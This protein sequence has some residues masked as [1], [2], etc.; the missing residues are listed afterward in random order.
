M[1]M[2]LLIKNGHVIDPANGIDGVTDIYIENGVVAEVGK[3]EDLDGVE[4]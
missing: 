3:N 4:L 1:L 2:K